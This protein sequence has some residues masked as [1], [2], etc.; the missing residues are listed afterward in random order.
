MP[1]DYISTWLLII[2]LKYVY[3]WC[4]LIH[5]CLYSDING[6]V[7]NPNAWLLKENEIFVV[8]DLEIY[9]NS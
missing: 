6:E 3:K 4:T 7:T 9:T 2:M 1:M 5:I 8:N